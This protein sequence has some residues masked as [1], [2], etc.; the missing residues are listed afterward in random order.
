MTFR[1]NLFFNRLAGKVTNSGIPCI[2][3]HAV[4]VILYDEYKA[5]ENGPREKVGD[6]RG[7]KAAVENFTFQ[8]RS[9]KYTSVAMQIAHSKGQAYLNP[10]VGRVSFF[11]GFESF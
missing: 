11:C 9:V 7:S 4:R 1:T 10:G 5:K 8:P 3:A 6:V 2:R